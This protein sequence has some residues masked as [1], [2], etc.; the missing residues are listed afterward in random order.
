MRLMPLLLHLLP[1]VIAFTL[2]LLY[3]P[4]C[5]LLLHRLLLLL[6]VVAMQ[7]VSG[8]RESSP[9]ASASRARSSPST[10]SPYLS[11]PSPT[12][13]FWNWRAKGYHCFPFRY[14]RL[15][16]CIDSLLL[17]LL[18]VYALLISYYWPYTSYSAS[19]PSPSEA[20]VD[21]LNSM[22]SSFCGVLNFSIFIGYMIS[23]ATIIAVR[24]ANGNRGQRWKQAEPAAWADVMLRACA[25]AAVHAALRVSQPDPARAGLLRPA[26][27]HA[28]LSGSRPAGGNTHSS[29]PAQPSRRSAC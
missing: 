23:T 20:A 9:P 10:L 25:T 7:A 8:I 11:H 17:C 2:V 24:A 22:F 6:L 4:T 5:S 28:E 13:L 14:Q 1:S 29:I 16:A 15:L 12:L 27:L 21:L 19:A 3:T 26:D 18:P